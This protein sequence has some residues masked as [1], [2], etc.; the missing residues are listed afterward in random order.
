MDVAKYVLAG[1]LATI[2]LMGAVGCGSR[3]PWYSVDAVYP[4]GER[5]DLVVSKNRGNFLKARGRYC[6]TS[7]Y[8]PGGEAGAATFTPPVHLGTSGAGDTVSFARVR[9]GNQPDGWVRVSEQDSGL[10]HGERVLVAS[11]DERGR[12][13]RGDVVLAQGH[14]RNGPGWAL[15]RSARYLLVI[16]RRGFTIR[17][18]VTGPTLTREG[19]GP[20]PAALRAM[21]S[22]FGEAG[23]WFM[24]DDLRYVTILPPER[25]GLDEVEVEHGGR[26]PLTL[27]GVEVDVARFGLLFD[28]QTGRGVAVPKVVPRPGGRRRD[29]AF[30]R[31][32]DSGPGDEVRLLYDATIYGFPV[33]E[34]VAVV[35]PPPYSPFDFFTQPVEFA[36][37][38]WVPGHGRLIQMT[39]TAGGEGGNDG[40]NG[41]FYTIVD[42]AYVTAGRRSLR[43][44]EADISRIIEGR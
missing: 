4:E 13:R 20:L 42:H 14:G 33:A 12:R 41:D 27:A 38:S 7:C 28:R 17:D 39:L 44:T 22:R 37:Q 19:D 40:Y 16:T 36:A 21:H 3:P 43:I 15:T 10:F 25:G 35:A 11:L 24:T 32:V 30:L 29:Y 2:V 26:F 31:D 34:P 9:G 5:L 23:V 18:V 1:L 6:A 8:W